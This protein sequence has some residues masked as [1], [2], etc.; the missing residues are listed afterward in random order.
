MHA[1]LCHQ[2]DAINAWHICISGF[3]QRAGRMSGLLR[4]WRT[5]GSRL[6]S[7]TCR[8]ELRRWDEDWADLADWIWLCWQDAGGSAPSIRVYAYSWGAGWGF[9]RLARELQR[10]GL[11]VESAVLADPV[12]RHWYW[13]GQWRAFVPWRKIRVPANVVNVRWCYQRQN[14]PR[15]HR[16]VAEDKRA[17]VVNCGVPVAADHEYVDDHDTF[18]TMALQAAGVR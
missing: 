10:R 9:V 17:T 15:G 2:P 12:Y 14:W 1:A 4:L 5:I 7:P 13:L 18:H 8:V 3:R 6:A 16:V 11:R